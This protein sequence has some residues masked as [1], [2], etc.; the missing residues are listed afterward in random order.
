MNKSMRRRFRYY[1]FSRGNYI[2]GGEFKTQFLK[3][4]TFN[5]K[6]EYFKRQKMV[7]SISILRNND[8]AIFR[9]YSYTL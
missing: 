5:L 4:R 7:V 2:Q 9:Y 3:I 6:F 8:T 1:N